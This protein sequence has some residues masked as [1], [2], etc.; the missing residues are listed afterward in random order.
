MDIWTKFLV[1]I[2]F[3]SQTSSQ[4]WSIVRSFSYIFL[5]IVKYAMLFKVCY[6]V[7]SFYQII[8]NF[9]SILTAGADGDVRVYPGLYDDETLSVTLASKITAL[10]VKVLF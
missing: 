4:F 2:Q 1:L 8:I 10:D 9:S 6:K 7:K 5:N 3:D